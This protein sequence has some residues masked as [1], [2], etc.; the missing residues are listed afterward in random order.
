MINQEQNKYE[1][2]RFP[3]L[4]Q[5]QGD[6]EKKLKQCFKEN[7]DNLAVNNAWKNLQDAFN[8]YNSLRQSFRKRKANFKPIN[9]KKLNKTGWFVT[10]GMKERFE[11][12]AIFYTYQ[13]LASFDKNEHFAKQ[14]YFEAY[15]KSYTKLIANTDALL[16][17]VEDLQP[18]Q[19]KLLNAFKHLIQARLLHLNIQ[20]QFFAKYHSGRACYRNHQY[21]IPAYHHW[22]NNNHSIDKRV[23]NLD[24]ALEIPL[25]IEKDLLNGKKYG[26]LSGDKDFNNYIKEIPYFVENVTMLEQKRLKNF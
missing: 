4:Q 19:S 20:K 10:D 9:N 17:H 13:K 6:I 23:Q 25:K 18:K 24:S 16:S 2:R 11:T 21:Y 14:T 3:A 15:L 1:K 8:E 5:T 26:T 12:S 7:S 22:R